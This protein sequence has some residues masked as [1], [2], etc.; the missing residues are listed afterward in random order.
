M[1]QMDL[2]KYQP[3]IIIGIIVLFA[4]LTLWTRG[5]PSEGLV[6]AEGVNLLGND[7]WYSLRQV[8]QSVANFPN[9]AWF[10]TMTLYPTG[11]VIYWGPLFVQIIA[12]LCVLTG[13][14]TRP[15]IML[16]ASWVPPLMAVAMVPVIYLLARK[17]ADWKTGLIAAGLIAVIGSNYA[18]RSLF[19]FVDHH[20]AETLFSTIFVLAYV[21]ALLAARDRQISL[22]NFETLKIPVITAALAGIAYLLGF[23]NM[24]TMVLFA[25]IVVAFTLVQFI[26]DFFQERSSEYLVLVNAVVFAAVIVGMAAF[27]FPHPGLGLSLYSIGHVIA[28]AGLIAGT[29]ALYG[30]SVFLKDRPKYYFPVALAA[31]AALAV[32]VLYVA[33]PEIYN[34][35]ISSLVSFFGEAAVTTTVQEARAWSFAA[36]WATFHWGLVLAAGGAA[37]LLW[38]NLERVNPAHVFV[39]IWSGI[40]LAS[41]AAHVRYEY[42][43]AA[44]I[45]LLSAVFAG[46]V[47]DATWKDVARLLGRGGGSKASP[48]PEAAEKQETPAKKGKKGGKAPDTRKAKAPRRDQPDYLKIGALA[49]VVAVTLLF[50]GTSLMGNIALATGA[51]YSGMDSEWMEAL[52]WMGENTPDPGVD[53]YAIYDKETFVYPEEAYGV[54]S[55]WDYGH[56]IT[57]VAKRIPNN[58]PFQH[59]VTGPNGSATYLISTDEEA[60][61]RVLDNIGTR[62]IVTDILLDTSKFHAPATW[63]D[64]DVGQEPFQPYYLLPESGGSTNYQAVPFNNQEYYLTMI[65]RLHNFD[66]SMTD[67]TSQVIYAEYL[68]PARA[69]TSLPVITRTQQ[70]NATEGA[71]AVEAYNQNAP[72]GS[73]ATLLNMYYQYR[74]DSILQ[75][76]ER[77]PALQ[78]Y[79]L[80]HETPGNVYGNVG[81]DG[82][83]L[84]AVKIF[85]YVPGA[86]I[87]G[88]GIIEV[89]IVTNTGRE[90]TYRQESVNGTF[91]VPYATSG[92]SGEVKATGQYRIAGTG[93]AFD[94]TEED[95]QQGRTIN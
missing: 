56:W 62:Y 81:E 90:F 4:L 73:G 8:E 72:P 24:P 3:Y 51:K 38:K 79:R 59:G 95:I 71:A 36:A 88:E 46:A 41:T 2:K 45:A 70:M 7:P 49:A 50:A 44:N 22:K 61:N 76:L 86:T 93:Q 78:H 83:D 29:L 57:F 10:D 67:P 32:A 28:Y 31:A 27:G 1:A 47:I 60:A 77:V 69:N 34:L 55:W 43:L 48:A 40:I 42:Y 68:E 25:L 75:P 84:K 85:E 82:P 9:Y 26:L 65:S 94:V 64:P 20:I 37:A 80:V 74:G 87:R 17:I 13:A 19:G 33:L 23:F 52:E 6:T 5:I 30:L 53:Y 58:N 92:W 14:A 89:P 11:D 91:V 15:E 18:Y 39:L 35:L 12:A 54:M 63:A 21:A 66:G 16:V